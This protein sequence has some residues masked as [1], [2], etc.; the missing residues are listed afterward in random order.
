MTFTQAKQEL[1][2]GGYQ[3]RD[4]RRFKVHISAPWDRDRIT[5]LNASTQRRRAKLETH[6]EKAESESEKARLQRKLEQYN[7]LPEDAGIGV[8][9]V[10]EDKP[11]Q[12]SER[13]EGDDFTDK[14]KIIRYRLDQGALDP[15]NNEFWVPCAYHGVKGWEENYCLPH[16]IEDIDEQKAFYERHYGEKSWPEEKGEVAE[17]PIRFINGELSLLLSAHQFKGSSEVDEKFRKETV[18]NM[19]RHSKQAFEYLSKA[20]EISLKRNEPKHRQVTQEN[21][22]NNEA[23]TDFVDPEAVRIIEL[24][25]RAGREAATASLHYRGIPIIA[26]RGEKR[27][28]TELKGSAQKTTETISPCDRRA[29]GLIKDQTLS[30]EEVFSI[31]EGEGL[32]K[33]HKK[34]LTVKPSGSSKFILKKTYWDRLKAFIRRGL[35]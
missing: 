30:M 28:S 25:F 8:F 14:A 6:I 27:V 19:D 11:D 17:N 20:V 4:I 2:K 35:C 12:H 18:S 21:L 32:L 24:A 13:I 3:E 16:W 31:L 15:S 5:E 33:L 34:G 10:Y 9:P 7:L 1:I 23:M 26:Q 29:L 22:R